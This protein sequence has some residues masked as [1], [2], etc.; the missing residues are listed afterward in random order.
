[1]SKINDY[2]LV[3]IITVV[4][5]EKKSLKKTINSVISQTYKNIEYIVIDGGSTDGTI[6][7]LRHH[8]NQIDTWISEPDDGVYDAMNKGLKIAS[9][10]WVNF[11]NAEDTFFS[12][13]TLSDIFS[14][15]NNSK[16]K[17]IYGDWINVNNKGLNF[18]AKSLAYLNYEHLRY[19]FQLN[20]QSLFVKN[21]KIP[22]FDLTYKIKADYQWVIDIVQELR[23]EDILYIPKALVNYDCE[24]LSSTNLLSNLKEYIYLTKRNF[25]SFQVIKNSDIYIKYLIRYILFKIRRQ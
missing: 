4:F 1:M 10:Q 3:S 6:D 15:I 22:N 23:D 11:L 12:N 9:G 20:H 18:Y 25:G 19:Q 21:N 8:E 16:F 13:D 5:N 7:V 24:G 14:N 17:L 2:P